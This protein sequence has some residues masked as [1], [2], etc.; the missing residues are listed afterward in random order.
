MGMIWIPWEVQAQIS[1]KYQVDL[2]MFRPRVPLAVA[3]KGSLVV[4]SL[5]VDARNGAFMHTLEQVL[6]FPRLVGSW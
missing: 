5:L 6:I 1:L 3:L 4:V 2:G